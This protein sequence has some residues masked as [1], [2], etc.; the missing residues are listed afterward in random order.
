MPPVD[1]VISMVSMAAGH[2]DH[3]V[4]RRLTE[5][6]NPMVLRL[7]PHVPFYVVLEQCPFATPQ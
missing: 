5:V 1:P 7:A 4:L 6:F 3:R 2:T